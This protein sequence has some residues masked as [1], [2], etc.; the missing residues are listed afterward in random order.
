MTEKN[1][2]IT[3]EVETRLDEL[4]MEDDSAPDNVPEEKE[5]NSHKKLR[6]LKAAILSIDWEINDDIMSSLLHRIKALRKDYQNDRIIFMFLQL[7]EAVGKYIKTNKGNAHPT[8]IK[9]LNSM[10]YNLEKVIYDSTMPISK[11]KNILKTEIKRF[12]ILKEQ[13]VGQK[14]RYEIPEEY[15]QKIAPAEQEETIVLDQEVIEPSEPSIP[16]DENT[17]ISAEI[18][19]AVEQIKSVIQSEFNALRADLRQWMKENN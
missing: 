16:V 1:N 18:A 3:N 13:I 5:Q 2:T 11:R 9:L 7:L 15:E 12:K 4:F 14:G 19:A 17:R 8:S 10:F 6:D